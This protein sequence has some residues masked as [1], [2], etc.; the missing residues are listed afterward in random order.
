MLGVRRSTSN[1]VCYAEVGYPTPQEFYIYTQHKYFHRMWVERSPMHDDPL[2]LAIRVAINAKTHTG[3]IENEFI[4]NRV[5][6]KPALINNVHTMVTDSVASRRF[7]YKEI[8]PTC[9]VHEIYRKRH[10][11]YE[12]HRISFTKFRVCG[13]SLEVETG[14]WNIEERLC[15][16]TNRK[17]CS[18]G[19]S[20]NRTI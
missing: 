2:S 20:F 17:T 12:N 9:Q 6:S 7:I 14:R 3:K 15:R 8:N 1:L 19:V 5:L 11:I 18:G 4:Q 16:C 13:H 10:L